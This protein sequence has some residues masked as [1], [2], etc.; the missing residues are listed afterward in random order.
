MKRV[1]MI[2]TKLAELLC[3]SILCSQTIASSVQLMNSSVM[4]V[5]GITQIPQLFVYY[6]SRGYALINILILISD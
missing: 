6:Q 4:L 5:G 3:N 2:S 1:T